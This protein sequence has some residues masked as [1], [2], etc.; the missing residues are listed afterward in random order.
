MEPIDV[1]A[2]YGEPYRQPEECAALTPEEA[3]AVL[4]GAEVG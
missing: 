4:E 3:A 1:A 2:V